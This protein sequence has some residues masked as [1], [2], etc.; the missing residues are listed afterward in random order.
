MPDEHVYTG[1]DTNGRGPSTASG[2]STQFAKGGTGPSP[3]ASGGRGGALPSLPPGGSAPYPDE[4]GGASAGE[5]N[6]AHGGSPPVTE[7]PAPSFSKQAL[8]GAIASCAAEQ[9]DEFAAR[10]DAL[11]ERATAHER[12]PGEESLAAVRA[13]WQT[14]MDSFQVLETLRFGPLARA[15]EDPKGRDLRD[16]MYAWPLGGRCNIETQL[17]SQGYEGASFGAS[18][19]N[20]RGLGA[21]EYLLFYTA[22]DNACPAYSPLNKDGTWAALGTDE[23]ARRKAR[24]AAIVAADVAR[25]AHDLYDDW[26]LDGDFR[27]SFVSGAAYPS[28]QAAL[29]AASNALFYV[30]VEVKDSK[31]G[32]PLGLSPD[33]TSATCPEALESRYATYSKR[34]IAQNL[35]GFR[36][37]F[38]G[39]TATSQ[40]SL[41]F[42]DWL[43]AVGAGDL[44]TR[45]LAQLEL[46]EQSVG[47]ADPPLE[48]LL[49]NDP[50]AV[51][52]IYDT[53]KSLTDLLKSEFVSVLE[54]ELPKSTEGDND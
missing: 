15:S 12:A 50:A 19:I 20:L 38:A 46:A 18:L 47:G 9:I 14:A 43:R 8:L 22:S 5:G 33:C 3:D 28:A 34:N 40:T 49:L 30:E 31:L 1:R 39:C 16:Q 2:G 26:K 6:V 10:A 13:A 45:M 11:T 51:R 24:Y 53:V 41:G 21:L 32:I 17:A 54:L 36:R 37:L 27:T 7:E 29:N 48:Q 25:H 23:L 44:S 42:D 52:R 4:S 35:R